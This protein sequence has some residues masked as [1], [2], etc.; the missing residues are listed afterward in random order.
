MAVRAN[1]KLVMPRRKRKHYV[2]V[3][4]AP[5]EGYKKRTETSQVHSAASGVAAKEEDAPAETEAAAAAGKRKAE[6]GGPA[7][8]PAKK[9]KKAKEQAAAPAQKAAPKK[10]ANKAVAKP[11]TAA[12]PDSDND[13][14]MPDV[15]EKAAPAK[16]AAKPAKKAAAKKAAAKPSTDSD[17]DEEMPDVAAP[18]KKAA[19]PAKK[20]A[21]KKAA[22]KPS[23]D[24]DSDEEMP[25][26][27]APAKKAAKPAKKAAAKKA[28]AKPSAAAQLD[29]DSDE[30]IPDVADTAAP[31]PK[32]AKPAKKAAAKKAAAGQLDKGSE[33]EKAAP[34]KKAKEV[35]AAPADGDSKVVTVRKQCVTV[36][37]DDAKAA[38]VE[39]KKGK[40]D[41]AEE[42][43]AEGKK[44]KKANEA[45][46]GAAVAQDAG[47]EK[48]GRVYPPAPP[49][50]PVWKE[51]AKEKAA[52]GMLGK[53]D[54]ALQKLEDRLKGGKFRWLNEQLYTTQS[55]EAVSLFKE[56]PS[57]FDQYHEGFREQVD[58]W[59]SNPVDVIAAWVR[60]VRSKMNKAKG[61]K[62][63]RLVCADLGCGEGQLACVLRGVAEVHSF[64]L[65]SRAPH[66]KVADIAKHVPLP[67]AS[68]DIVVFCLALMGTNWAEMVDQA[69]RILA[70]GG[71]LKIAEVTSRMQ[72][73]D[74][75]MKYLAGNGFRAQ[76]ARNN[77][78]HFIVIDAVKVGMGG[79]TRYGYVPD[80]DKL[81]TPCWYK[82][83]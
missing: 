52:C 15:A 78:S 20:A 32:A 41:A 13:E 29:S 70:P 39:A 10:A 40:V 67:D 25:D 30:E 82:R 34:A 31:A 16:K 9:A 38:K 36:L 27:A 8:P 37:D 14:E 28:A 4:A 7:Q 23:T 12:Q 59:P 6:E 17:S 44:A 75:F 56:D 73:P 3:E 81:L 33:D 60:G 42:R 50:P 53:Q 55:E 1:T 22:A 79:F 49:M 45:A 80:P 76:V 51:V 63:K 48:P 83:R 19:K 54:G 46:A 64:D 62:Q 69:H 47:K 65:V 18:A 35:A 24:S 74:G 71:T 21:A 2:L 5:G 66:I 72:D 43:G 77:N 57:L 61:G 26:V 58:K 68:V 11:S